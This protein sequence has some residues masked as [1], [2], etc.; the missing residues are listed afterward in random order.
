MRPATRPLR[1]WIFAVSFILLGI[2]G[3]LAAIVQHSRVLK[4][5][6]QPDFAYDAMRPIAMSGRYHAHADRYVRFVCNLV[7]MRSAAERLSATE[8]ARRD[9]SATTA[10]TRVKRV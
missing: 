10:K 6:S 3:L 5:L 7:V 2:F 8:T 4:R 1:P 9:Q